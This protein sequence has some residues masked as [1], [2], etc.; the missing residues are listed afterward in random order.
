MPAKAATT[1]E[2]QVSASATNATTDAGKPASAE[3]DESEEN[4]SYVRGYNGEYSWALRCYD[5]NAYCV[6]DALQDVD[7]FAD[8][9][10][11]NAVSNAQKSASGA[12]TTEHRG[13][14]TQAVSYIRGWNGKWSQIYGLKR[15]C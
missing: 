6:A 3:S 8:V 15:V 1:V 7:D 4:K 11:D 9:L 5:G 12:A 2:G 13:P 10:K 14:S